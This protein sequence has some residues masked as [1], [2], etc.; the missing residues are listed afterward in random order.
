MGG[1]SHSAARSA[2]A[3][4]RSCRAPS[5]SREFRLERGLPVW[6]FDL[7][8]WTIEKRL[9]LPH[10][11]NTVHITYTLVAGDGP[12]RLDLGPAL[13]FRHHEA[14]VSL[15]LDHPYAVTV[16]DERYEITAEGVPPLRLL[17][18]GEGGAL[19]IQPHRVRQV[20][21]RMEESRGYESAGDWWSPGHFRVWLGSTA[22]AT[23]V[24]STESWDSIRA[25]APNAALTAEQHRRERLLAL[26]PEAAREGTPAELVLAADQ[27]IIQPAGRLA[28]AARAHAAGDEVR[29][30]IAGYHWFTDW[31]R[32]TMISFD[33]LT[34]ATGRHTEAGYILRTFAHYVRDGLIPNMFPDGQNQGLYHTADATLWYFHAAERY[35]AATGDRPTLR[36][37]LPVFR[38]IV[39]HHVR[40]TRFG[41]GVDPADGLL[42]QG[43]E[44]YQ[45]TWMDA[46]VDDWVV[47]PRRGKAVEIN[48]LWYNALR[49]LARWLREEEGE[50]HVAALEAMA[51]RVRTSFNDRFWYAEGGYL[52]D[53]VDGSGRRRQ[54]LPSEPAARRVA[55]PSRPRSAPLGS[56]RRN[57]ARAVADTSRLALPRAR[58]PRLQAHVRRRPARQR[59]GLPSGHR[60][61]MADWPDGGRLAARA[62]GR[63]NRRASAARGLYRPPWGG[64]HR[65]D[66]RDFR[67]RR[68]LHAPGLRCAGVERGGGPP[69]L[70]QDESTASPGVSYR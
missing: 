29:T 38:D 52:R 2:S 46:K 63:Q 45:L 51:D 18:C 26:A 54:R 9:L 59:R 31:G 34:L 19:T 6:Q 16:V 28:D 66:Q 12:V 17:V 64:V 58:P 48:A 10:Q 49:L 8:G 30:V 15:P 43:A 13:H 61:G 42:R 50:D 35:F 5:I 39:D 21:Y 1:R 68:A 60:V 25:L 7:G 11:Q 27:F 65:L 70:G 32:D 44:G 41:I 53:V 40:G 3:R 24:A 20:L 33:G 36:A 4:A 67:C 69:V 57:G 23:L 14:P 56:R 47:T 22:E 62:P 37:L 55:R